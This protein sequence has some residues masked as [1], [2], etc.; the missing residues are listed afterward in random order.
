[1]R[2]RY[3]IEI[4]QAMDRLYGWTDAFRQSITTRVYRL[5]D[6]ELHVPN[7]DGHFVKAKL[8]DG[9][10]INLAVVKRWIPPQEGEE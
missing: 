9:K 5:G 3:E 6:V 1:M 4:I 10:V 8:P 2:L 7:A